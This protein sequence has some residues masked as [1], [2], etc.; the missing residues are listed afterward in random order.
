MSEQPLQNKNI[1][2]T[3]PKKQSLEL[4]K[5]LFKNGAN[6]ISLPLLAIQS[7]DKQSIVSQ[8]E[9]SNTG[10]PGLIF[11]SVNAVNSSIE[12]IRDVWPK[13]W[14][15]MPV[16]AVGKKTASQLIT[17]GFKEV[18]F[19]NSADSEGLLDLLSAGSLRQFLIFRANYGREFLKTQL[20]QR[21]MAIWYIESYRRLHEPLALDGLRQLIIQNNLDAILITSMDGF[22]YLEKKMTDYGLLFKKATPIFVHHA[23]IKDKLMKKGFTGIQV[24]S[25]ED[26]DLITGMVDFFKKD[27]LL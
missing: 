20:E 5:R 22:S 2:I 25:L 21:G 14:M 17:L 15:N 7:L 6:P 4:I 13:H 26:D 1:I 24:V 10:K 9:H 19:P 3:R 11:I 18:N 23:A 12:A 8:I 27:S 16:W